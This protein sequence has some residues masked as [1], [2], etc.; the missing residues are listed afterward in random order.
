MENPRQY[1]SCRVLNAGVVNSVCASK[2]KNQRQ[3]STFM[4][5]FIKAGKEGMGNVDG[6]AT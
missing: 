6:R 3:L 5:D 2:A 4:C 1:N